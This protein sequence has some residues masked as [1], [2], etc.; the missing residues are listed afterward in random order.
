MDSCIIQW[1]CQGF[2]SNF[3][4]IQIMME[5]FNPIAFWLQETLFPDSYYC[6][7]SH[8]TLI[9]KSSPQVNTR[10]SEGVGILVRKSSP[11]SPVAL[12]TNL[13]AVACH[14]STQQ[15]LTLCMIDLPHNSTWHHT[16]LLNLI[17]QLPRPV[18]LLGDFNAH[19]LLWG[20]DYTDTKGT[21]L[22]TVLPQSKLCG[23]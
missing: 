10:I 22:E 3:T 19:S 14:I 12:S 16:D 7:N 6:N 20:C 15:P 9:S 1:N 13:Q 4:E 23:I 11:H 2:R 8:Y 18:L 17:S 5:K 21:E